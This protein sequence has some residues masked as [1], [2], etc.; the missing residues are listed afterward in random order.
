[1][2]WRG[3]GR[4]RSRPVMPLSQ[5]LPGG[6]KKTTKYLSQD[7]RSSGRGLNAV[8]PEYEA[9]GLT[10]R[11]QRSEDKDFP[12]MWRPRQG[13]WYTH[14][15]SRETRGTCFGDLRVNGRRFLKYTSK[16]QDDGVGWIQLV[17]GKV[18]WLVVVNTIPWRAK[19]FLTR[20]VTA[21]L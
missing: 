19:N 15:F 20:F 5:H 17:Q 21:S 7:N 8:L 18:Q 10:T 2:I 1:M 13:N 12:L 11:P 16:K 4:K 9:G 6:T 14:S 3:C